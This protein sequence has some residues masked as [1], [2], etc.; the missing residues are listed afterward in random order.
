[1][2]VSRRDVLAGGSFAGLLAHPVMALAGDQPL[3]DIAKAHGVLYGAA[4]ATVAFQDKAATALQAQQTGILVP[5][6]ELKWGAVRPSPDVYNLGPADRLLAFAKRHGMAFRGHNLAWEESNPAWLAKEITASN[7]EKLLRDHIETV[8]G[9]FAGQVHSWD[10]VNEPIWPQHN[11][12]NGMRDGVWLRTLGE[13]YIDIAFQTARAADPAALLVLNEAGTEPSSPGGHQRRTLFL[14]LI[15][16][17]KGRGVPLDAVGLEC[18]FGT[19]SQFDP[20]DFGHYLE[21]LAG[22]GLRVI[23]SELDVSDLAMISAPVAQ[24]DA[25]VAAMYHAV[26]TAAMRNRST[27]A[28]LTWELTDKFSWLRTSPHPQGVLPRPLPYDADLQPKPARTALAAALMS[29]A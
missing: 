23:I 20:D 8:V 11:K 17:L 21:Q 13:S 6:F 16:R 25:A 10:V 18:H 15:D 2:H 28:L 4:Y 27:I 3:R 12:P 22:R 7:A 26:A 24:R 9:H 19:A 1:M 5:D 29:R 14:N